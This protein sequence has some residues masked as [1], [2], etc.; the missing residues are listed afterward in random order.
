MKTVT[1]A[2]LIAFFAA[3]AQVAAQTAPSQSPL[4]AADCINTNQ[5]ND[6]HIV[7]AHTAI[8]RTGPKRY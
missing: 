6:W 1:L 3:A 7:D 8:V 2:P 5:I 4:P